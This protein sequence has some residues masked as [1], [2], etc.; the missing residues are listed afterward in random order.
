MKK[1]VLILVGSARKR[2]NS[3][4]LA[5]EFARGAK[6]TGHEVEKIYIRDKKISGCLGCG[7]CQKNGGVCVQKDDM[8]EIYEKWLAS[9]VV[10][11]VSPVYFYTWSAQIK[12][13]IDR[14]F[15]IE[16]KVKDTGFYLISTG[17]AP[18]EEYMKLMLESFQNYIG[19]FRAG[20]NKVGGYAFGTGM[21]K[22]GDVE[23]TEV[24][25]SV[26]KMGK[27]L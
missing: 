27:N 16:Q 15:A 10:V 12:T 17:A 2:G 18:S 9:D 23:G 22:P 4:M 5:D 6:E 21:N 19:C 3:S 24:M 25:G 1:K 14:T 11:L 13:V 7:M 20:G 8:Q 26:Y